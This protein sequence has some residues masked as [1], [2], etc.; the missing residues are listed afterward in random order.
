MTTITTTELRSSSTQEAPAITVAATQPAV[1]LSAFEERFQALMEEVRSQM[2]LVGPG[3]P[4]SD[5][6]DGTN[7]R[8]GADGR[9]ASVS[10]LSI[11]DLD[12]VAA[13]NA[14]P[15]HVLTFDG[16]DWV[17]RSVPLVYSGGGAG[18]GGAQYI[19]EL[20]DVDTSTDTPNPGQSL[21]W[22]GTNWIPGSVSVSGVPVYPNIVIRWNYRAGT[23]EPPS[24]HFQ[25]NNSNATLITM[26]H[27]SNVNEHNATVTALVQQSVQSATHILVTDATDSSKVQYYQLNGYTIT[28][29]GTEITVQ[30]LN[31]PPAIETN[32]VENRVYDLSF[33]DNGGAWAP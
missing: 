13:E 20:L 25:G 2:L 16:T 17:A 14:K 28:T 1:D 19:D 24:R 4:G 8:D 5:G 26:L 21:V 22:N 3:R 7:G 6:R 23:G 10:D 18:G 27:V 32:F 9:D 12:D 33:I 29:A 15:G 31:S 11:N 30:H